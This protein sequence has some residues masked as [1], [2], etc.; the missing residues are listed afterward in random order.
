MLKIS[1]ILVNYLT[2]NGKVD[3]N[4]CACALFICFIVIFNVN[5]RKEYNLNLNINLRKLKFSFI[6]PEERKESFM[7]IRYFFFCEI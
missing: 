1:F 2:F 7:I 5:R 3:Y 4:H 6:S